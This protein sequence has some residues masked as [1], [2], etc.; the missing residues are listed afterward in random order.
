MKLNPYKIKESMSVRVQTK[1]ADR[2]H[3]DAGG[4]VNRHKQNLKGSIPENCVIV[5]VVLER[6]SEGAT[7]SRSAILRILLSLSRSE[8]QKLEEPLSLSLMNSRSIMQGAKLSTNYVTLILGYYI[9]TLLEIIL[10]FWAIFKPY[11]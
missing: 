4:V 1:D 8:L 3:I 7:K 10:T 2:P 5:H 9:P 6:H 11:W